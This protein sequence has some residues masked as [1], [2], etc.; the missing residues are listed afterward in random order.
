M[1]QSSFCLP[2]ETSRV[3]HSPGPSPSACTACEYT[4]WGAVLRS[5]C[6][7][8]G[9]HHSRAG[10]LPLTYGH[11]AGTAARRAPEHHGGAYGY[12]HDPGVV[13]TSQN[14]R[15]FSVDQKTDMCQQDVHGR[16]TR[17]S[18]SS[19]PVALQ[20]G[21]QS[22]RRTRHIPGAGVGGGQP[23]EK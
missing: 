14:H 9:G 17:R 20:R 4:H 10:P 13:S 7:V 19:W 2:S 6:S 1:N 22:V 3:A 8:R 5:A 18:E 12:W 15:C 16:A 23:D 11:T 21:R